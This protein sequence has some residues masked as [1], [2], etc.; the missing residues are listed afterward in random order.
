MKSPTIDIVFVLCVVLVISEAME[1]NID[2]ATKTSRAQNKI[3]NQHP[4]GGL[5]SFNSED[6]KIHVSSTV[7]EASELYVFLQCSRRPMVPDIFPTHLSI[8]KI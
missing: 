4:S 1:P 2:G 6:E 7:F 3:Y 8:S 5:V